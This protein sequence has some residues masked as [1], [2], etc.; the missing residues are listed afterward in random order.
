MKPTALFIACFF[1]FSCYGHAQEQSKS[2]LGL[3]LGLDYG[4]IGIRMEFLPIKALGI[5][6]GLG[7]NLVNPGYNAG[8]SWKLAPGKRGTPVIT[9]MYGYNAA[10]KIKYSTGRTE[11]H[12]YNGFTAGVGFELHNKSM[13]NKLL[14][15]ILVPF[16]SSS[17][18][19]D[20]DQFKR[21]GVDLKRVPDVAFTI[22]Y[23]FGPGKK[24]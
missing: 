13:R 15:Q 2:Y 4:G 22:G 21:Q 1:I 8:L 5:F 7:Y 12:T 23:N 20:Y 6:G 3:G 16:R 18:K 17:F 19:N 24:K 10:I 9:G 14:C 11:G